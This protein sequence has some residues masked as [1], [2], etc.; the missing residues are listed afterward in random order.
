M[1]VVGEGYGERDSERRGEWGVGWGGGF[2]A[3]A[4]GGHD[5]CASEFVGQEGERIGNAKTSL[6]N[7]DRMRVNRGASRVWGVNDQ[8]VLAGHRARLCIVGMET[9]WE[10]DQE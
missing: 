9:W 8:Y 6:P 2:H 7:K 4:G 1:L 3:W 10:V 5:E